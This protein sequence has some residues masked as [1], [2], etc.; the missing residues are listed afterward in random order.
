MAI[1][2]HFI[3]VCTHL[4]K[5]DVPGLPV[6][7][8]VFVAHARTA[9]DFGSGT[10]PAHV[11]T[12]EIRPP[13]A[14]VETWDLT[15]VRV[16]VVTSAGGAVS[17][18]G[19][20]GKCMPSLSG[21]GRVKCTVDPNVVVR[22]TPDLADAYFDVAAGTFEAVCHGD[23]TGAKLTID[24]TAPRLLFSGL[25]DESPT[26]TRVLADGTELRLA[27]TEPTCTGDDNHHFSM[28]YLVGGKAKIPT[29]KKTHDVKCKCE[30]DGDMVSLGP[31]CSNSE[32]P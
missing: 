15:G 30:P 26:M 1:T 7:H 17:Y 25:T 21:H 22:G 13:G 2:V 31:G 27:H 18:G 10:V 24:G 29:G 19:S 14:P 28:H 3:G 32:Y 6:P 16:R 20:W 9:Q 23:A 5:K 8:R 12:L 11:A 4:R